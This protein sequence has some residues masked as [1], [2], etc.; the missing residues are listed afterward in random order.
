MS[1]FTERLDQLKRT[2]DFTEQAAKTQRTG[3]T[4][5]DDDD[6]EATQDAL[7]RT[8]LLEMKR[9]AGE[10]NEAGFSSR[11]S[12]TSQDSETGLSCTMTVDG[13][14]EVTCDLGVRTQ[15]LVVTAQPDFTQGTRLE[16]NIGDKAALGKVIEQWAEEHLLPRGA[17]GH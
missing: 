2:H 16:F 12:V 7:D 3:S 14:G 15:T 8:G 9:I 4:R 13:V 1:D 11:T 17:Q 10:L 5:Q 6:H